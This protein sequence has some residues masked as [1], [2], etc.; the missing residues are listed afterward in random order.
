MAEP[1]SVSLAETPYRQG[2]AEKRGAVP[3]GEGVYT[4]RLKH[5]VSRTTTDFLVRTNTRVDTHS[6]THT[7]PQRQYFPPI[8]QLHV[9]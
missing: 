4:G 6:C 1:D 5:A 9:N 8:Y 7:D 3:L 2:G